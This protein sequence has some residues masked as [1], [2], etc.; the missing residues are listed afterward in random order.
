MSHVH[1]GLMSLI[2]QVNRIGDEGLQHLSD[3]LQYNSSLTTIIFECAF[4]NY[5][6]TCTWGADMIFF[7]VYKKLLQFNTYLFLQMINSNLKR[8]RVWALHW[9][10]IHLLHSLHCNVR[11]E[12]FRCMNMN[13]LFSLRTWFEIRKRLISRWSTEVQL[14]SH[15]VGFI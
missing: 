8:W 5:F 12:N 14:L 15:G 11:W 13:N 3:A 2:F 1:V 6:S 7:D 10:T 9:H 4:K